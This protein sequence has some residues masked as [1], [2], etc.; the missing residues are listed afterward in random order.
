MRSQI[1]R[2]ELLAG[3]GGMLGGLALRGQAA[4]AAAARP[5]VLFIMVDEMRADA[6]GCAGHPIVRTPNLDRLA[7]QGVRFANTY[8]VSP[9]CSPA[10]ASA[11]TGR[12]THVHGMIMNGAPANNGEI[13]LPSILKHYGYHT[14]ISGKLHYAPVR[15][16][17]G[18]DQFWSFSSEGPTPELGYSAFLKNKYGSPAKW[19]IVPGTCPWP[20]DA[21]GRD[22]G[23][24]K[25]APEDFESNWITDR[26]IDYLRGRKNSAQPWFLFTSYL[27]PH[28]PSVQ[29][30]KYLEMYDPDKIPVPKLPPNAKEIRAQQR[31]QR[32][33]HYVDDERII[34]MMR[35][36][37]YGLVTHTDEQIGRLLDELEQLGMAGNTLVLFTADHGNMLGEHGRWFKGIM[38]EGSSHI[39][40][41]WREPAMRQ[42]SRPAPRDQGAGSRVESKLVENTDLAP[43]IL[44][45]IGVP[46]PEGV[47]GKSFVSLARGRDPKWKDL[48]YAQLRDGMIRTPEFKFIDNSL[49]GSGPYE[50]YDMQKDLQEE[51]NLADSPKHRGLVEGF[52]KQ[53]ARWRADKPAPVKIAGMKTP[54]YASVSDE[55][56][57]RLF[58]QA[59]DNQEGGLPVG[60][61]RKA[62]KEARGKRD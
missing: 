49:E 52:K 3:A 58:R 32:Q 10:R 22:Y 55:E 12:Y 23:V 43:S 21:L 48:A 56:R 4:A 15:Y 28:S 17:F 30:K 47:Q 35:A 37:Y 20:E 19:P 24:F 41:I 44:E 2:R 5:N 25:H 18:F 46:V 33:R 40:L 38:Y 62:R 13:Y 1:T 9:V 61:A 7:S 8:T 27:K 34:R 6:M 14:A 26:A 31:G 51:N 29:P 16:G 60:P 11:F 39:P 54:D 59:P 50:L 42:P 53:L 36:A 45:T 57:R